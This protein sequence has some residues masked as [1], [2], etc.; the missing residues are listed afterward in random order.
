MVTVTEYN[1]TYALS[2]TTTAGVGKVARDTRI[3]GPLM[4]VARHNGGG[5]HRAVVT[6]TPGP[7]PQRR[8]ARIYL[9]DA[10]S[11]DTLS[12]YRNLP[13]WHGMP[14]VAAPVDT[15]VSL[16]AIKRSAIHRTPPPSPEYPFEKIQ[17]TGPD[18]QR[19]VWVIMGDGYTAGEMEK[20]KA[21]VEKALSGFFAVA[22]WKNRRGAFNI[23]RV[24]V[25]SNESGAD[26][27]E[28]NPPTLVDTA[29]GAAYGCYGYDRLICVDD[30]TATAIAAS[31]AAYDVV[32]VIVN[33]PT[34]GGSGGLVT[35]ASTHY[36][37][38][39]LVLHEF[40]HTFG[41]LADEYE[42]PYPGYPEGDWEPNVSYAY[43]FDR[44]Q[45]KWRAWIETTTPLPTPENS[46]YGDVAGMFEGA[47]YKSTG[48]YRPQE[49]CMM[50]MLGNPFCAICREAQAL[51][52]YT[53]AGILDGADPAPSSTIPYTADLTV[54]VRYLPCEALS[55]IFTL[56]GTPL[57]GFSCLSGVCTQSV[58]AHRLTPG[59][60]TLSARIA[61]TSGEVRTDPE[62]LSEETLSWTILFEG[63]PSDQDIHDEDTP[64]DTDEPI[65]DEPD[66]AMQPDESDETMWSDAANDIGQEND[67]DA[68]TAHE[69]GCGCTLL[70]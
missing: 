33:D 57:D 60:N 43:D 62:H 49:Q 13:A 11:W 40:G 59:S 3:T 24:D 46:G 16:A 64:G 1:G 38:G 28:H 27:L 12:L 15:A 8:S 6:P 14:L 42:E 48:I 44:N 56:N 2:V 17:E 36:L 51:R 53:L 61:D 20:F 22:P 18:E 19:I 52:I 45:I 25:V 70:D 9:P 39:D 10:L 21:D 54:E 30:G 32:L 67:S 65:P 50:R 23:Y 4:L 5:V 47:R 37:T 7:D 35:V 69:S 58:P 31:V 63:T 26:H 34:Y 68:P 29:L 66:M 41:L 55:V